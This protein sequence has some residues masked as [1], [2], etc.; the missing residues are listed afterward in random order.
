MLKTSYYMEVVLCVC[1]SCT[2]KKSIH[3]GPYYEL[4]DVMSNF[5][6]CF[7]FAFHKDNLLMSVSSFLSQNT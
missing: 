1:F 2:E 4:N 7:R 5:L 3:V 6:L